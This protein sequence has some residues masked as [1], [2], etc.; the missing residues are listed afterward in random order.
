MMDAGAQVGGCAVHA[1]HRLKPDK[2]QDPSKI[3]IA[4]EGDTVSVTG[5]NASP[6]GFRI[7][8]RNNGKIRI[9]E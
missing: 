3:G 1:L 5:L 6:P 7:T 4:V 9:R 8:E 2:G